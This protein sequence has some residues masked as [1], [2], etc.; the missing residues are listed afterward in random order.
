MPSLLGHHIDTTGI[1][2]L[3]L[4]NSSASN[5]QQQRLLLP[6]PSVTLPIQHLSEP[7]TTPPSTPLNPSAANFEEQADF[8]VASPIDED[9]NFPMD[10]GRNPPMDE[11]RHSPMDEDRHSPMDEDR[12][13]FA[14]E[15][16]KTLNT[17]FTGAPPHAVNPLALHDFPNDFDLNGPVTHSESCFIESTLIGLMVLD[18]DDGPWDG[19]DLDESPRSPRNPL[20]VLL[21]YM[22]YIVICDFTYILD[23]PTPSETSSDEAFKRPSRNRSFTSRSSS[24]PSSDDVDLKKTQPSS[25]RNPSAGSSRKVPP[26]IPRPTRGNAPSNKRNRPPSPKPSSARNP[27]AGSSRK[28]PPSIPRPTRG[29]APSNK[30]NRPPSPKAL[31]SKENP[32]DVEKVGSLFEPIVIREYVWENILQFAYADNIL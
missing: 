4:P 1:M 20:G 30:R 25:A 22:E 27:S 19:D 6:P 26:S 32:I 13:S 21:D 8:R 3:S 24:S 15:L 5:A 17:A 16:V 7:F 28:V 23:N 31:G 18:L 11:D 12:P 2:T 14:N 29:N 10:E 9:R